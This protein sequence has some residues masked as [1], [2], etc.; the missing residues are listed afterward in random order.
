MIPDN[1]TPSKITDN[2]DDII[3]LLKSLSPEK[4]L[5]IKSKVL[6]IAV[7]VNEDIKESTMETQKETQ[8]NEDVIC[9]DSD[10]EQ[11]ATTAAPKQDKSLK[12]EIKEQVTKKRKQSVEIKK[13]KECVNPN[14]PRNID[15]EYSEC[16]VFIMTFYYITRK[17]NKVQWICSTCYEKAI[18]KYEDLASNINSN[19]PWT[20]I[21]IPKKLD[22]LE[23][24]DSDEEEEEL[25]VKKREVPES[26]MFEFTSET[27]TM[28]EEILKDI[29]N[30]VDIKM[31]LDNEFKII[32]EKAEKNNQALIEMDKELRKVEKKSQ[33]MY[34]EL[35]AINRPKFDRR[36]SLH[37]DQKTLI[38]ASES[39]VRN[40]I[41]NKQHNQSIIR[42]IPQQR[43]SVL[44]SILETN[45][46]AIRMRVDT[47]G[48]V[49]HWTPCKILDEI[50]TAEG[51]KFKVQFNDHLPNQIVLVSGKEL[52]KDKVTENLEIG[53]RV[54][55]RFPRSN[56]KGKQLVVGAQMRFLPGVV[57]EKLT[58]YNQRRFLIFCDYG[59]VKYCPPSDVREVFETSENVWEDVHKN[60]SQFI[61][62]YLI[63]RREVNKS[64][65]M[66]NLQ[67]GSKILVEQAS[68][69]RQAIVQDVD[70][71]LAK[72]F[73]PHNRS[74]EWL[75]RGSK[76]L[77]PIYMQAAK[78]QN[79][80]Q[81]SAFR[82]DPG[83]SYI[84][85]DDDDSNSSESVKKNIAKKSTSRG[86]ENQQVAPVAAP[87]AQQDKITIL[88][89][90]H[91]Y[92]EDP[93]NVGRVRHFTPKQ[94]IKPNDYVKHECSEACLPPQQ[95][96]LS[97]FSPLAKPLLACW[98]RQIV[99]QKNQRFVVYKAP[100]GRRLR[101]MHEIFNYLRITKS[102]LN[103]DN[104][105]LDH[106]TQVLAT[107]TV[108]PDLCGYYNDDC[109]EKKEAMKIPVINAFDNA[110]PPP[111][112]YSNK[113][114]P[115]PGVNINTDPEF[116]S[117]C[118]CT[119]DCVDK[120]KCAC[121]QLTIQGVKFQ[122]PKSDADDDD[123]SY[124]WK[125]LSN[126]VQTGIY[127]CNSRCKCSDRCLNKVV[128]KPIAV[129]MMLFRTK[130]RGWG[131]K[132]VHDI[133][134][135]TFICI[136]AG[137]L[138]VEK[139]ANAL[140]YGQEHGDEYFA[141]LDLIEVAEAVKEGYE[142][143]VVYPDSD[144]EKLESDSDYDEKKDNNDDDDGDFVSRSKA[145]GGREILTRSSKTN[146][147]SGKNS[148][149]N[150]S[151]VRQNSSD[152]SDN[153][154]PTVNMIPAANTRIPLRKL[155]GLKERPY[156][157]DAKTRGNIGRYFNV[158][159]NYFQ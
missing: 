15:D 130:K 119:D 84:A 80:T 37:I 69:W 66:L 68:D 22:V 143:G 121:F 19:L 14:C 156:V 120:S 99:R 67:V 87:A 144:D 49:P 97:A 92:L 93:A 48:G 24:E 29:A 47:G 17:P 117:C 26:E 106:T 54:I 38:S 33:V 27:E 138:Y 86:Q 50:N 89:D 147:H 100:C 134:K 141:E 16:P 1:K 23:I 122:N 154:I 152:S 63:S 104:F 132:T 81:R 25:S 110:Q 159:L 103:V 8:K 55:A 85:I 65:A 44:S 79:T 40:L 105:D 34:D 123:I 96:N 111:L 4:L 78:S 75:Y 62:D 139:D 137:N 157:M 13:L 98:E 46:F 30:R 113:R 116:M 12:E 101:N 128:Q 72:I 6:E 59:Q 18:E 125:R 90:D 155:F 118:D 135:G 102:F 131:L 32:E 91:I 5:Q 108:Q 11:S 53:T 95:N 71:S 112:E 107:Y 10:D 52:A 149:K 73:F 31:Q 36:P 158:S 148:R 74:S 2:P 83:I 9:L 115:M 109:T 58:N 7:E 126:A 114:I 35:Y 151:D 88:N 133:P 56:I 41:Q 57:G 82:R 76:R 28:C 145:T 45:A 43:T 153:E 77:H 140:C 20:T 124:I 42:H 39:S 94:S 51:K 60:L 21:K 70:C 150:S 129:K 142:P 136:Y 61:R 146:I 64:R 127:E 3:N